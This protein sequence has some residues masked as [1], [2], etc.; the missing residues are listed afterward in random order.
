[1]KR[2]LRSWLWR[3][4]IDQEIDEE[5][6]LHI[7]MRT[8][9]LVDRGM[10]PKTAHELAIKRLGDL[11]HL[12]RTMVDLGRKRDREM[13]VTLWLEDTVLSEFVSY[14]L[15]AGQTTPLGKLTIH[16]GRL[17]ATVRPATGAEEEDHRLYDV[18]IFPL[19][20]RRFLPPRVLW[21]I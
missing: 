18:P 13:R 19:P 17:S 3:M 4:P 20:K 16:D 1:M 15:A 2:S 12:K 11:K 5:L 21:F 7:E 10:D 14:P 8:R 9:E 6:A